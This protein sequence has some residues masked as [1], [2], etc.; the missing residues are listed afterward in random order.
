MAD[1]T[2]HNVWLDGE[3]T[4]RYRKDAIDMGVTQAT[5]ID[6]A[7]ANFLGK[8]TKEERRRCFDGV[9]KKIF[10]RKSTVPA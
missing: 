10:G 7:I 3:L 2:Q 8:L 1:R 6:T 5:Y 9:R 4:R